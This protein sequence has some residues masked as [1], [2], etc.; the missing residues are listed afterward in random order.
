MLHVTMVYQV[1]IPHHDRMCNNKSM[2]NRVSK[3]FTLIELLIVIAIIGIL[4]SLLMANFIGIR[5]RARDAQRKSDL[6]QIRSALEL[7]RADVGSYPLSS[8]FSS[9]LS[10]PITTT[11][12]YMQQVPA[13]PLTGNPAYVYCS[14]GT[15]YTIDAC[16]E[17][18]SDGDKN[19]IDVGKSK[20][21]A[22]CSTRA[23]RVI[24]P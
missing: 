22:A 19:D 15:T 10:N 20:L 24:N 21:S 5:Q 16:L 8:Q 2:K 14:D 1:L 3:G 7:Y 9:P 11:T 17:N 18:A 23:Y 12:V 13:D 6:Q 4:S